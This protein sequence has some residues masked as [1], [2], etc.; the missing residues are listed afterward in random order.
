MR[1]PTMLFS[2]AA[3]ILAGRSSGAG[4]KEPDSRRRC[5]VLNQEHRRKQ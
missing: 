3:L 5:Y 1:K 4:T 2:I